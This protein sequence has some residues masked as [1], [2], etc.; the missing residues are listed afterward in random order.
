M[1]D[2][3][4]PGG[5]SAHGLP[6]V[7]WKGIVLL[8]VPCRFLLASCFV[9]RRHLRFNFLKFERSKRAR[10][11]LSQRCSTDKADY[12]QRQQTMLAF[13]SFPFAIR[14]CFRTQSE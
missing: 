5:V 4:G 2:N 9:L 1:T 14:L 7:Q 12:C 10:L 11:V 8:F 6:Y 3:I 13:H